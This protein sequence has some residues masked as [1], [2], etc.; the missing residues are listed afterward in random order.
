MGKGHWRW[1][2]VRGP[3][4]RPVDTQVIH[5]KVERKGGWR[6]K[7]ARPGPPSTVRQGGAAL[8]RQELA[9]VTASPPRSGASAPAQ[10]VARRGPPPPPAEARSCPQGTP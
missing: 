5:D 3:A 7:Q 8:G 1:V 6:E 9:V 4:G 10:A 2:L